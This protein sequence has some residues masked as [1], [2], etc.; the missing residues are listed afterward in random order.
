M[1]EEQDNREPFMVCV[2]FGEADEVTLDM[3]VIQEEYDVADDHLTRWSEITHKDEET[4]K[5]GNEILIVS[6]AD[7]NKDKQIYV[8]NGGWTIFG[9][10]NTKEQL[11]ENMFVYHCHNS[12]FRF[13]IT[14]NMERYPW[15]GDYESLLH[16]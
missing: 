7:S 12:L 13:D 15:D 4:I 2:S 5:T 8:F 1:I 14:C 6:S 10:W 11:A 16:E 3:I 9:K